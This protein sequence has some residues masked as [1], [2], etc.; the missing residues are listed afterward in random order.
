MKCLNFACGDGADLGKPYHFFSPTVPRPK[1][2]DNGFR[3]SLDVFRNGDDGHARGIHAL[4]HD[5]DA[6]QAMP[7]EL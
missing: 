1:L 6:F 7:A 2:F 4:P 3:R 5:R